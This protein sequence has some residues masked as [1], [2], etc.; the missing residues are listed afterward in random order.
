ML[1]VGLALSDICQYCETMSNSKISETQVVSLRERVAAEMPQLVQDLTDLV[2]IE[3]VSSDSKK[4]AE[5][6]ESANFVAEKFKEL[7]FQVSL[8]T[9]TNQHKET[10][11]PAVLA[12]KRN[13]PGKPTVLLYAHHDVQPVGDED[14]WMTD[15][16]VATERNGRLFG[17]GS[18][19]DGAGIMS[20]V[21]ALRAL[22][23][24]LG[25][26]VVVFIE[27][28]EEIGSPTFTNFIR[29]NHEVL[30][31]DVIIVADSSVWTEEIPAIT[32]TLRGLV[33]LDVKVKVSNHSVHSG[34]FGGPVV[35]AVTAAAH[36]ISTLHDENGDVAVPGLEPGPT[37][38]VEWEENEFLRAVGAVPGLELQGTDSLTTR[39]WSKPAISVIGMDVTPVVDAANAIAPE[40]KFRLSLRLAPQQDPCE[41]AENLAAYVECQTPFGAEVYTKVAEY[42]AGFTV[43]TNDP[44]VE[45]MH[46]ALSL[47]WGSQSVNIGQGGSIP[48][49]ADFK[50]EFP[51]AAVLITGIEDA[52]SNAHSENE[53]VSLKVLEN[54]TLAEALFLASLAKS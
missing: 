31:A 35:D 40:C 9:S 50:Q 30:A 18:A 5:I 34:A 48:F 45:T 26:N 54:A 44:L 38:T 22:G 51:Q 27:G 43:D 13:F 15:P 3:S 20:H 36:L 39:L 11:H 6:R 32:A 25:V 1:R 47:A 46:E 24:D 2:A 21:G 49:I 16:L 53:S 41:A 10:G 23:D 19:D 29:E 7:G 17:R 28:E 4:A 8:R 12:Q 52:A 14:R 42:G 33:N 37:Q